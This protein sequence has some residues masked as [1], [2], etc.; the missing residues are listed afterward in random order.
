MIGRVR[1]G[2]RPALEELLSRHYQRYYSICRR[3]TGNDA[4]AADA[5]QEALLAVVRGLD[6]F[7]GTSSFT[8]W[9]YR[10]VANA[11][12]DEM[13]RRSRRPSPR[14][15]LLMDP[16]GGREGGPP[17]LD[18]RVVDHELVRDGL[19]RMSQPYR[20]A[21][22][23]RDLLGFDYEEIAT[24]LGLPPGTVRSRIARGRRE[25]ANILGNQMTRDGRHKGH[26]AS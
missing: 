6:R 25:L 17:P 14:D 23:L 10:V 16:R 21:V 4:D 18:E 11:C 5:T 22:V 20:E 19:T 9:S 7:E 26:D 24:T 8:T 3:L 12:L 1:T 2:D 15:P 13:R